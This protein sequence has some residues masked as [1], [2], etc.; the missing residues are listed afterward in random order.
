MSCGAFNDQMPHRVVNDNVGTCVVS[1]NVLVD[2]R[3]RNI[4][5]AKYRTVTIGNGEKTQF[6]K[7]FV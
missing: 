1:V 3:Q 4:Q 7:G 2:G 6:E 5:R